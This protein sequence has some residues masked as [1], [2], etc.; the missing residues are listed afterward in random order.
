MTQFLRD[1]LF[2]AI[3]TQLGFVFGGCVAWRVLRAKAPD[4][5][6]APPIE[7]AKAA[8][9]RLVSCRAT[10]PALDSES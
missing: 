7:P 9:L 10:Y 4:P 5:V 3:G 1:L 8:P 6:P 2:V